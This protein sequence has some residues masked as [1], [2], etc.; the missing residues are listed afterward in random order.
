MVLF[1]ITYHTTVDLRPKPV[2]VDKQQVPNPGVF[3]DDITLN[4][5]VRND[6]GSGK[7]KVRVWVVENGV[8]KPPADSE[9][10]LMNA[11]ETH[12]FC[13]S[14]RVDNCKNQIDSSK[15]EPIVP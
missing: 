5:L 6:G 11:G 9:E 1:W 4:T 12:W 8:A 2:I 15:R 13:M 10:V 7:V 3:L 14:V